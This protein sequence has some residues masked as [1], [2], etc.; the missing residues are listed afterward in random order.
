MFQPKEKPTKNRKKIAYWAIYGAWTAL[1]LAIG[2]FF[3]LGSGKH[4]IGFILF[5]PKPPQETFKKDDLIVLVLGTD[6]DRAPGGKK[7]DR[8]S[9]R[10]DVIMVVRL[11]FND[12]RVTGVSIPRDTLARVEGYSVHRL[13]AF[14]ALGGPDLSRRAVENITGLQIDRV[15]VIN[16]DVFKEMVDI[17]DGID[18]NVKKRLKYDD[19]RGNLHIDFQPGLQHM[20]G[21]KA[22]EYVR[23]RRDSDFERQARQR[24][25]MVAFKSQALKKWTK[26]GFVADKIG[27]LTGRAFDE[28]ELKSLFLFA[29]DL[30]TEKINLGM[31]PIIEGRNYNLMVDKSKLQ[32]TLKEYELIGS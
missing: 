18:I 4:L 8:A 6:E 13:N 9:A 20:D 10:S 2:I 31:L 11:H 30:K 16:Y 21:Q 14:H 5:P 22:M 15:I 28:E 32:Q 19:E 26:A 17:V 7:I 1:A 24:Q 27:D 25:F 12:S 23:Y 29:K 3:G